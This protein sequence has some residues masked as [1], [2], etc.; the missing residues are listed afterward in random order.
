M[1]CDN[2]RYADTKCDE[3]VCSYKGWNT[4]IDDHY[5]EETAPAWC[6]LNQKKVKKEKQQMGKEFDFDKVAQVKGN[7]VNAIETAKNVV[8]QLQ[9]GKTILA[10]VKST[11]R[12]APGC[13]DNLKLLLDTPYG[14]AVVGLIMHTVAPIMTA[15]TTIMSAVKAANLAGAVALSDQFTFIQDAVTNAIESLPGMEAL[16]EAAKDKLAEATKKE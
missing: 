15:N 16:K 14:D 3:Y 1:V 6:P 9:K 11:L 2:C 8:I 10:A 4:D 12:K 5:E 7:A 13:P